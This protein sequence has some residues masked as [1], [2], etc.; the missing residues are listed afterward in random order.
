MF[1]MKK[2]CF[3]CG[4]EKELS[5]FY[6]HPRMGDG[7]L[8]KCKDC[9][10][11]DS[12]DTYNKNTQS[13]KFYEKERER[14]RIKYNKYKYKSK[15]DKPGKSISFLLKRRGIDMNERESHHWNYNY[16]NNVFILSR[17]AHAIIH[18][19]MKYDEY[20]KIF[21]ADGEFLDTKEK[22]FDFIKKVLREKNMMCRIE[23][24]ETL[25]A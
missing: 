21:I 14:G 25:T 2:K 5:E 10:R 1:C 3:K 20:R 24:F 4:I 8:N 16:P 22:H 12:I 18:S 6:K 9:T 17:R 11:R 23:Y 13:Q 19:R 7:H 15:N